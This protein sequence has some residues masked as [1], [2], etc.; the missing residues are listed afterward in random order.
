MLE[1]QL[2]EFLRERL[3]SKEA[4][5]YLVDRVHEAIQARLGKRRDPIGSSYSAS[6]PRSIGS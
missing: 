4:V 6:W 2:L 5:A 3:Y 1:G